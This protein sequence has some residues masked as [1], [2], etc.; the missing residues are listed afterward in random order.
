MGR[1]IK[2]RKSLNNKRYIT[3]NELAVIIGNG[4]TLTQVLRWPMI[5]DKLQPRDV[6]VLTSEDNFY[7]NE[8]TPLIDRFDAEVKA[9]IKLK[10]KQ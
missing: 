8:M 2:D 1:R 10:S 3:P 6:R 4:I 7:H 9:Y 5:K